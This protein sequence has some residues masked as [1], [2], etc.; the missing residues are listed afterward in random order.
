MDITHCMAPVCLRPSGVVG[1]GCPSSS[2]PIGYWLLC[3]HFT[4]G[5]SYWG[6][7]KILNP[8]SL[9]CFPEDQ[10]QRQLPAGDSIP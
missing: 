1:S 2:S 5:P 7:G 10:G 8:E 4:L 9:A 6:K 3:S